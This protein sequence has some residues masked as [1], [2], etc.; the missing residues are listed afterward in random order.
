MELTLLEIRNL[1]NPLRKLALCDM[2]IKT[3]W[4]LLKITEQVEDLTAK[5]EKFRIELVKKYGTEL[6]RCITQNDEEVSLTKD[7][8][9]AHR[10]DLKNIGNSYLEVPKENILEFSSEFESLLEQKEKIKLEEPFTLN[11]F[12]EKAELSPQDLF[13]LQKFFA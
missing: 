11:D 6:Y 2:P 10:K 3:S 8:V 13:Y 9:E 5:I 7:E 4:R 1:V 12:S